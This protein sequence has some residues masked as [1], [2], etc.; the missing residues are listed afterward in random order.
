M[1][2]V[3]IRQF[4]PDRLQADPTC[5]SAI[6]ICKSASPHLAN[7]RA[8]PSPSLHDARL[9]SALISIP[10]HSFA[11]LVCPLSSAPISDELDRA[12]IGGR[13]ACVTRVTRDL[14]TAGLSAAGNARLNGHPGLAQSTDSAA[15]WIYRGLE[16]K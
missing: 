4:R 16:S 15:Q 2:K 11:L 7:P 1:H 13:N 3:H 12:I 5:V 6:P 10:S 14:V 9:A 8:P